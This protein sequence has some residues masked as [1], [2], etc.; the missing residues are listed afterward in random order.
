MKRKQD[1]EWGCL[2]FQI[3][4]GT[5]LMLIIGYIFWGLA[6]EHFDS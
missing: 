4:F 2:A 3:A 6:S 1:D 5:V